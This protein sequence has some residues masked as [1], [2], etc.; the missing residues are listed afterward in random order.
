[1]AEM[2][3]L[4]IA[5]TRKQLEEFLRQL[6]PKLPEDLVVVRGESVPTHAHQEVL[7]LEC[8]SAEFRPVP[9]YNV[10]ECKTVGFAHDG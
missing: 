9:P 3:R 6:N 10:I 2:N 4:D 1:M 5:V 7:V 8:L